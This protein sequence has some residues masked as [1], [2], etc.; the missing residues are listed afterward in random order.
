VH[1]NKKIKLKYRGRLVIGRVVSRDYCYE[2]F[3]W[4]IDIAGRRVSFTEAQLKEAM[5]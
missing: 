3:G 2:Q 4:T 5:R 1:V